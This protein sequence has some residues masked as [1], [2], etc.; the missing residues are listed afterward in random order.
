[1]KQAFK[2]DGRLDHLR[3]LT[4]ALV[5]PLGCTAGVQQNRT[6][7]AHPYGSRKSAKFGVRIFSAN[8]SPDRTT[9]ASQCVVDDA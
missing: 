6:S 3:I 5:S 2:S 7:C 1:M 9:E 8:S 4:N